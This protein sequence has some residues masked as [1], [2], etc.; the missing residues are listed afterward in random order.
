MKKT[1]IRVLLANLSDIYLV[2]IRD[3]LN[4]NHA[5]EETSPFQVEHTTSLDGLAGG[6]SRLHSDL[7]LVGL[8]RKGVDP[9]GTTIHRVEETIVNIKRRAPEVIIAAF[10]IPS[11]KE[12]QQ[13]LA[14]IRQVGVDAELSLEIKRS[15]LVRTLRQSFLQRGETYKQRLRELPIGTDGWKDYESLV[16]EVLPFL[17]KGHFTGF[18]S[19]ITQGSGDRLDFVCRNEGQHRFCR[20]ILQ[21]HGAKYVVFEAKNRSVPRVDHLRQLDAFLTPATTGGF[22]ILLTRQPPRQSQWLHKR[23]GDLLKEKGKMLIVLYDD[24]VLEM[25]DMR[26]CLLEPMDYLEERYDYF[27]MHM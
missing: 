3:L 12:Y 6:V 8:P 14:V 16:R 23:L 25:L 9:E 20:S 17:F 13:A 10:A 18:R 21:D 7:L 26:M 15:E 22:G 5:D 11:D 27:R 1:A 4:T 19:Q 2:G 24:D